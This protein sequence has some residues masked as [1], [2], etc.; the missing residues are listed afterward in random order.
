MSGI[1]MKVLAIGVVI[2]VAAAGA[3]TFLVMNN[4][5]KGRSLDIDAAL[6]VYGNANNDFEIDDKDIE[7]IEKVKNKEEGYTLEKY[8]LADAYKDDNVDDKDIDQVKKI[9]AGGDDGKQIQ[10]WYVNHTTDT[11][12]FPSGTYVADMKW[13]VKKVVANGAANALMIYEIVGIKNKIAGINYSSG[14]PPDSLIYADYAKMESLGSSTMYIDADKL[15]ACVKANPE[16]TA[17]LTADNKGYLDGSEGVSENDLENNYK[18]DVVRIQH[19]AVDPKEYSSAILMVGFMLDQETRAQ[20]AADWLNSIYK[21]IDEKTATVEKKTRVASTS[22][23]N[24]LSA[25][26]SDYAD[27]VVKAGGE[28]TLWEGTST[29]IYFEEYKGKTKTYE[30]DSRL[31]EDK[32][33]ADKIIC[34]RTGSFLGSVKDGAS[35]YGSTDKWNT[36]QMNNQIAHFSVFKCYQ[37]KDVYVISGDMPVV[38]RVLYS[39]AILYPD[40]FS[41]DFANE[42]H[43][44]FVDEFLNGAYDVSKCHFA[45]TQTEIENMKA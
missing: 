10:V 24:Y 1:T 22:Y 6:E 20:D 2:V 4:N 35:W 31:L 28:Y 33:Q 30:P 37:N 25:R 13:P 45:L 14:S 3:A 16:V 5:D 17:V 38:A 11:K 9:M 19:A 21:E 34:I 32:Y 29:S 36:T 41:M 8:P 40:L 18:L 7:I 23:W 44:E 39:A 27:V 43:Q 15:Q 42:K 26:N 12:K